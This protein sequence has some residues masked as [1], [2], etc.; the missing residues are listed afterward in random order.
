MG[1]EAV[2]EVGDED[3]E[4]LWVFKNWEYVQE[5]YAL[6]RDRVDPLALGFQ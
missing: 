4:G 1:D 3:L 5:V 6:K 2:Q